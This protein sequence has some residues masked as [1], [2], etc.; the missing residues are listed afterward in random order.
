MVSSLAPELPS[1]KPQADTPNALPPSSMETR[2]LLWKSA[3]GMALRRPW[4][5]AGDR[6]LSLSL[7]L[8]GYGPEF[9]QYFF[10][11]THPRELSHLNIGIVYYHVLEAH[12]NTLN[13]WVELGFFGLASHFVLLGAVAAIGIRVILD[14]RT[15]TPAPQRLVMAAVLASIAGRTVEQLAGIPHISDEAL[16]WTLLVVVAALPVL[17]HEPL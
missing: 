2:L 3:S 13:R 14:K 4:F 12:N 7:H 1:T 10:P 5:Q 6:P 11:L 9:F 17:A 8:F 15:T 16:F